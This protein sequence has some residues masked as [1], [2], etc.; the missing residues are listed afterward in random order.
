CHSVVLVAEHLHLATHAFACGR[1][2]R[3][4]AT[5]RWHAVMGLDRSW[6][7][8]GLGLKWSG[9]RQDVTALLR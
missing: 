4:I 7:R 5:A 8:I 2:R 6:A 3:L 1:V 9:A